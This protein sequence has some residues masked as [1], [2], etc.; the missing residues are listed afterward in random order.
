ME[1]QSANISYIEQGALRRVLIE[2]EIRKGD[3]EKFID[4]VLKAGSRRADVLIASNGGDVLE[5]MKI[6][7]F[8]R[9][10]RFATYAPRSGPH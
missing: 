10:F 8:I 3:F 7:T 5:A 2:G 4:A 9:K 6:G 1:S